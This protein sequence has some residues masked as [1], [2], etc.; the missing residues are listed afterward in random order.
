MARSET[1]SFDE[2]EEEHAA[3]FAALR[4]AY[5]DLPNSFLT[6]GRLPALLDAVARMASAVFAEGLLA[7]D[8]KWM[9]AHVAS[10][11]AG[12]S[13]CSAHTGFHA[14][15]TAGVTAGKVA[16]L[17]EF[18]HSELFSE[19]EVAA[20]R[21]A[22]AAAVTPNEVTDELFAEL[23]SHFSDDEIAEVVA[24]IA[25]YGFL[26]R[27]NDTYSSDLEQQPL[28]FATGNLSGSGWRPKPTS[29]PAPP[30]NPDRGGRAP[31]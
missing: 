27:W 28:T 11:A 1:L 13:Y 18:E 6:L 31:R 15:E 14:A 8:L 3:L 23:R 30:N 12:C 24:P 22:R 20:L 7:L 17:W 9:V 16:A 5:G 21:L 19:P 10:R 25:F 4:D 2:L 29:T 26:N